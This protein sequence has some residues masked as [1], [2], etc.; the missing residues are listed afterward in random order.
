[1]LRRCLLLV[2]LLSITSLPA[3]GCRSCSSCHDYDPPVMGCDGCG[4]G[5]RAGSVCGCSSCGC[6]NCGE[7][8]APGELRDEYGNPFPDDMQQPYDEQAAPSQ[9]NS[10]PATDEVGT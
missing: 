2:V 3:G 1:M 8:Q 9:Q 7:G 5:Q 10:E 6:G 4:Y